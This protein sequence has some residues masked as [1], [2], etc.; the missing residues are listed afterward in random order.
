MANTKPDTAPEAAVE[1]GGS[2]AAARAQFPNAPEPW[3]DLSTGINPVAYPAPDL[4]GDAYRRLPD[5]AGIATLEDAAARAYGLNQPGSVAAAPGTQSLIG[6]IPQLFPARRV[7]ILAP[8]YGEYAPAWRAAGAEVAEV[9]RFDGLD[10]FD[11]AVVCNPNNPDG[12]TVSAGEICALA[13]RFAARG[14]LVV[15]DEAFAD[16]AGADVSAAPFMPQPGLVLLRSFGKAYGLAGLRLGFA[17][18][19]PGV[20]EPLRA[21]LG[22]WPVSGAAV[23][24]GAVALADSDWRVTTE[25]RLEDD[26]RRLDRLLRTAGFEIAGGT[27]LFRL[28][29]GADAAAAYRRLGQAGLF[30]RRFAARSNWLRFGLPGPET[31]WARLEAA[32]A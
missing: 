7:G 16:F 29:A 32:L 25:A 3:I 8:T 23:R 5:P 6:L 1:H 15:V 12:R 17:L 9:A 19:L 26:I 18:A 4:T 11:C 21:A 13:G 28:A 2:L 14:G 10:G 20:L 27:S 31:A 22:P 24:I 30:V